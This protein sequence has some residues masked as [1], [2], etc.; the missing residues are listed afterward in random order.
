MLERHGGHKRKVV[1]QKVPWHMQNNNVS[2]LHTTLFC[3]SNFDLDEGDFNSQLC[4]A[5]PFLRQ[6][7][8]FVCGGLAMDLWKRNQFYEGTKKI[9]SYI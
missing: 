2:H 9:E 6:L 4:S 3:W 8:T 7:K 5:S 1:N